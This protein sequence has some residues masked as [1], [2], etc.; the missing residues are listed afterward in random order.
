MR[1]YHSVDN[2]FDYSCFPPLLGTDILHLNLVVAVRNLGFGSSCTYYAS[3]PSQITR[4]ARVH[5]VPAT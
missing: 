1:R 3:F 4:L 5:V 2:I